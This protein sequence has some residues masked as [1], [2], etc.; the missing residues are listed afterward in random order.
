M[1]YGAR[2][3]NT[4]G[5]ASFLQDFLNSQGLFNQEPTGF[6]GRITIASIKNFQSLNGITPTGYVGFYTRTKI[7]NITCSPSVSQNP[8]QN[9]TPTQSNS[10][11][12]STANNSSNRPSVFLRVNNSQNSVITITENT[13]LTISWSSKGSSSCSSS[14]GFSNWSSTSRP[15]TGSVELRDTAQVSS[16]FTITCTN[17]NF[18]SS[19]SVRVNV[20]EGTK[21][22][23]SFTANNAS[24]S[25]DII[26][27]TGVTFSWYASNADSCNSSGGTS[28]WATPSRP[29][30]GSVEL[31]DLM[32]VS[33][34]YTLT[35]RNSSAISE[36]KSI[37]I[38]VKEAQS[39]TITLTANSSENVLT[40]VEGTP[41]TF[42]WTTNNAD[43]CSSSGG[44]S[45]WTSPYRPTAAS[46]ELRDPIQVSQMF[47]LNCR[48]S[49]GASA[50]KSVQVNVREAN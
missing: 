28:N 9:I 21:P 11:T 14:G 18:S 46:A 29:L 22:I 26:E 17:G 19:D 23:I 31:R 35:C 27:N 1:G 25:L 49:S 12:L 32:T 24:D 6:V 39:P 44:F 41:L 50:A 15:L 4:N 36:S 30:S 42:S 37:R 33:Q 5:E 8:V 7:K 13:S 40:M 34:T 3:M 48:N 43:F 2:D 47:T 20:K 45:N 10:V 16:T 38:N